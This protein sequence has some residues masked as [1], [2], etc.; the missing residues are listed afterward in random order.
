MCPIFIILSR[1]ELYVRV[2]GTATDRESQISLTIYR[3]NFQQYLG[4]FTATLKGI[5]IYHQV[6]RLN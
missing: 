4:V 3:E 5:F 1:V 6:M 2:V